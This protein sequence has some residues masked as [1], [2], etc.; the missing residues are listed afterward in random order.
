MAEQK[1][2]AFAQDIVKLTGTNKTGRVLDW[3]TQMP[4]DQRTLSES[5]Y[6]VQVIDGAGHEVGSLLFWPHNGI[7]MV[8]RHVVPQTPQD[9]L[10][11][12]R[13]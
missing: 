7:E 1:I 2:Y 6:P 10:S 9:D 11:N 4:I 5:H 8:Q 13:F 3:S 12:V